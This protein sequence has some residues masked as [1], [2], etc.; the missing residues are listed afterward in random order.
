MDPEL[1]DLDV[2]GFAHR[3]AS[4]QGRLLMLRDWTLDVVLDVNGRMWSIETEDGDLQRP[5]TP[6]EEHRAWFRG[7]R[8]SPEL[9][10]VL[11]PRPDDAVPCPVCRG[12]GIHPVALAKPELRRVVCACGGAGWSPGGGPSP[13]R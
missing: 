6:W 8:R 2:S 13:E 4:E 3:Y 1:W 10:P 5:S 7:V 11:P 9:V 12:I